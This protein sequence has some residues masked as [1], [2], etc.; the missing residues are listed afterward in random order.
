MMLRLGKNLWNRNERNPTGGKETLDG[1]RIEY[2]L[3]NF[4]LYPFLLS[5]F[6]G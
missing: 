2:N 3:T 6:G 1:E 5:F 4:E